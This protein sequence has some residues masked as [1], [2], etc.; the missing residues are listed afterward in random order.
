MFASL[1]VTGELS[2]VLLAGLNILL[3]PSEPILGD[4]K[5]MEQATRRGHPNALKRAQRSRPAGH[6]QWSVSDAEDRPEKD[7]YEQYTSLPR[8]VS[9]SS[10]EKQQRRKSVG[11]S[12]FSK[13]S[14]KFGGSR[15]RDASP[16]KVSSIDA[17]VTTS[18]K[19]QRTK[20]RNCNKQD[21]YTAVRKLPPPYRPPADACEMRQP[22]DYC[23][24]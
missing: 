18:E 23:S 21:N 15:S 5:E 13:I 22:P 12:L 14:Q 7:L 20:I 16:E 6:A 3:K 4:T 11:S 9:I 19:Q 10:K 17:A 24:R 1:L 2:L 8:E